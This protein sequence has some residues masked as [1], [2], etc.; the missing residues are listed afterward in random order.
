MSIIDQLNKKIYSQAE[1]NKQIDLIKCQVKYETNKEWKDVIKE[2][3]E[4]LKQGLIK[5]NSIKV[6]Y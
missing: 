6:R 2:K 1:M 4:E 3:I 5:F